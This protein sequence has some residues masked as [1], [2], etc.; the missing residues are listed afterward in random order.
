MTGNQPEVQELNVELS[1][2]Q[3][4]K[5]GIDFGWCGPPVCYTH[6][7]LPTTESDDEEWDNGGDPCIHII[8]LYEDDEHKKSVEENHSPSQW[9]NHY[10]D[11]TP[12]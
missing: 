5:I 9:R 2:E 8:R 11:E 6:D 12:N 7:G 1:F 3:W 4:M 10:R